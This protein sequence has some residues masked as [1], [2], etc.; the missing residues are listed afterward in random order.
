M[1]ACGSGLGAASVVLH[2]HIYSFLKCDFV[3]PIFTDTNTHLYAR[4]EHTM[5]F[6][7]FTHQEEIMN[8]INENLILNRYV[9]A[10]SLLS[11][12]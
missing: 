4:Y 1:R 5:H 8:D 9:H 3:A 10:E 11:E 2:V 6:Q 12:Q 7:T